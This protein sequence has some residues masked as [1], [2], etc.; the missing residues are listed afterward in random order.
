MTKVRVIKY[1]SDTVFTTN[2]AILL[3]TFKYK[4]TLVCE[5][6]SMP[7]IKP[8][9]ADYIASDINGFGD[10]IGSI[11]NKATNMISLRSQFASNSEEYKVLTG[12]IDTMMNYQQ[13][14]ID[15]IKGVVA[16]PLP[17]EWLKIGANKPSDEDNE[18]VAHEKEV[19]CRIASDIKP[20]FFIY[21]YSELKSEVDKYLAAAN[22]RSLIQ[23]GK[24]VDELSEDN[25]DEAEFKNNFKKY[26]PVSRAPGTM[27]R[28]CWKI[29]NTFQNTN[30]L[31][32]VSF[33]SSM[34]KTDAAYTEEQYN[35]LK[36]LYALYQKTLQ[37]FLKDK[38]NN[39]LSKEDREEAIEV[40]KNNFKDEYI[41]LSEDIEATTN[42]LIDIGYGSNKS[43]A[44]VWEVAGEQIVRNLLKTH[45]GQITFPVSDENGDIDFCGHKFSLVSKFISK[46]VDVSA[47]NE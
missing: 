36:D 32:N 26:M 5:Q 42:A 10:T 30:V 43:K 13:N 19:N 12:R 18:F 15:R 21:R 1:D 22:K 9:E 47:D 38:K 11:T 44:F 16:K 2:N 20:W 14:A 4:D 27:N 23:F 6:S 28:L 41:N 7:K 25:A 45:N 35:Y 33:D 39:D 31:T 17:N 34:L 3:K 37:I 46:G 29:E 8:T 40:L 24:S